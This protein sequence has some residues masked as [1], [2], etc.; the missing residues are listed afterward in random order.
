MGK[1]KVYPTN[2][3]IVRLQG[4]LPTDNWLSSIRLSIVGTINELIL[5]IRQS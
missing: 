5:F 1:I 2:M 4:Q 3:R